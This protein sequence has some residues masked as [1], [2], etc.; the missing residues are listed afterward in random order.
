GDAARVT[1][2]VVPLT[3]VTVMISLL[4]AL[5]STVIW[6]GPVA[7]KKLL[8]KGRTATVVSVSEIPAASL[9]WLVNW[10]VVLS[11]VTGGREAPTARAFQNGAPTTNGVAPGM[12]LE[13]FRTA[14]GYAAPTD[15]VATPLAT[16]V[17]RTLM[18]SRRGEIPLLGLASI[19]ARPK[20]RESAL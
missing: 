20:N 12:S 11:T 13:R 8:A 10:P 7:G 15:L 6:N 16:A 2:N 1:V 9:V 14:A 3:P 19:D 18:P 5:G 17:A 4:P